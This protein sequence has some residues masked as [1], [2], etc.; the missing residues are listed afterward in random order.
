MCHTVTVKAIT[1]LRRGAIIPQLQ[2]LYP[3]ALDQGH[4]TVDHCI[5]TLAGSGTV[6]FKD[7]VRYQAGSDY[8][9]IIHT[10]RILALAKSA[11]S[12]SQTTVIGIRVHVI[13]WKVKLGPRCKRDTGHD[14]LGV[15][16]DILPG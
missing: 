15:V 8:E 6:M 7:E 4:P 1:V 3:F 16:W 2:V 13:A 11:Q 9:R 10:C 5:P 14:T 12:R